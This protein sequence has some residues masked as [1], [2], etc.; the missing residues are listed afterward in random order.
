NTPLVTREDFEALDRADPLRPFRQ[1][2]ALPEGLIYL[3]GNSL[4]ALPRDTSARLARLV[5]Q[6][7]GQDLVRGWNTHGWVDL[8]QRLGEKIGRLVGAL[9]GETIVADSTSVNLFKVLAMALQL[10]PERRVILTERGNFPADLYI[11][12]GLVE[13]LGGRH[14]LRLVDADKVEAAIDDSV[15]VVMLTHVNYRTGLMYDLADIT[16]KAH[17]AGALTVW[18]LAHSAGAVPVALTADGA[19]FAVGCGYKFLN[20]GPGAPAFLYVASRHQDQ[21]RTPLSGWFGHLRPFNFETTYAPAQGVTRAL[22]GTPSIVAMT[23]LEVGVDLMLEADMAQLRAKSLRQSE[24]FMA[25]FEQRLGDYGFELVSP[26]DGAVRGSQV[27]LGHPQGWPIMR[28]LHQR[29]VIGDFRAPDVLRFGFC[30]LYVGYAEVWD[31]MD[32]LADI[33]RSGEWRRAEYQQAVKVT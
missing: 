2:F 29:G 23:A 28:A 21:V 17:A 26:R 20:G 19:D 24:L 5:E 12:E 9:P 14:E 32:A 3:N 4:G 10:R 11:A 15:A 22:A 31:A 7:W 16:A 8:P 25:L 13:L 18:D 30:P 33:M 6:E 27:C 1:R